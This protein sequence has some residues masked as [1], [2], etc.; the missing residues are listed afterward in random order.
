MAAVAAGIPVMLG[1]DHPASQ[2]AADEPLIR[3]EASRD[4]T[5]ATKWLFHRADE[6]VESVRQ[7]VIFRC[8]QVRDSIIESY[9]RILG[10]S[11]AA[12]AS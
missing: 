10:S 9:D 2:W 5:A 7:R 1:E 11:N 8:D 4:E 6:S 3:P 12:A